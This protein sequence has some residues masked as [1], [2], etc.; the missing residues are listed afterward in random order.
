MRMLGLRARTGL[1]VLGLVGVLLAP[2]AEGAPAES[3][4]VFAT[5][6]LDAY[7]AI[8]KVTAAKDAGAAASLL[9]AGLLTPYPHIAVACGE[10][11]KA[12]GPGVASQ[13]AFTQALEKALRSK[14]ED[15][16]KNLARVLGAWGDPTVDEPLSKLA[17]GRKLLAVQAEALEMIGSLHVTPE[18]RFPLCVAAV[19]AAFRSQQPLARVAACSAAARIK[20][21]SY[22]EPL[23]DLARKSQDEYTGLYAISALQRM[24]KRG[25]IG[26]WVRVIES[27]AKR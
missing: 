24:G 11:L 10:A 25:D 5:D 19:A 8:E 23:V 12:L 2:A 18:Q 26:T 3:G 7:R 4:G 15:L 9:E 6:P 1:Q 13:T 16:Q 14:E 20:D 21:P 17:G 27:D 22:A